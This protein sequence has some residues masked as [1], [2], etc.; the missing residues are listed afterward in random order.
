MEGFEPTFSTSRNIGTQTQIFDFVDQNFIQLNYTPIFFYNIHQ[1][2][3][4]Q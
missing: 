4:F 2:N 1:H 3:V